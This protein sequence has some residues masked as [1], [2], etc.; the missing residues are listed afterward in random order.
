MNSVSRFQNYPLPDNHR[1]DHTRRTADIPGLFKLFPML[2][3][4]YWRTD[5]WTIFLFLYYLKQ[6]DSMLPCV[7]SV[8]DHRRCKNVVSTSVTH[9]PNELSS[10][11]LFLPHFDDISDLL[12]NRCTAVWN[13]FV[14]LILSIIYVGLHHLV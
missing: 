12:L 5:A 6:A 14:H 2:L 13:L 8:T 7:Y 1:D 9:S 11:F 3:M 10:T 4:I